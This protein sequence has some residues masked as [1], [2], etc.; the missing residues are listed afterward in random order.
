[1][2]RIKYEEIDEKIDST[3]DHL[4]NELKKI[5][6]GRANPS[7]VEGIIVEAYG[8]KQPLKNLATILVGD[9]NLLI[10]QP[11]DPTIKES[12][13]KAIQEE[14]IGINPQISEDQIRLPLPSLTEETRKEY[15]NI[16]KDSLEEAKIAIRTIRKD[17][18]VGV[19]SDEKEGILTEDDVKRIEKD[20]QNKVDKANNEIDEI[21]GHKEKEL[22]TI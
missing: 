22:L 2:A 9:S 19:S 4:K 5:R 15:V 18:L 17:V 3:I 12:I 1:M 16:M 14:N 6:S 8:D 7:L 13:V 20:V 11:W 10:V 21:G